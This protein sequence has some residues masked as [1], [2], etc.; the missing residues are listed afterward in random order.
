[1]LVLSLLAA[2]EARASPSSAAECDA[3]VRAAPRALASYRCYRDLAHTGPRAEAERGLEA[4]LRRDRDN[5]GAL[6]M[7]GLCLDERGLSL[8]EDSW[9]ATR[10]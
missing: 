9:S 4:I 3:M 10:T 6:L 5:P 8:D 7:L 1:M 2:G